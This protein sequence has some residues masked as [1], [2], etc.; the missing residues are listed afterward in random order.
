MS[1]RRHLAHGAA[2]LYKAFLAT[3]PLPLPVFP[4]DAGDLVQSLHGKCLRR[5]VDALG[6]H[7]EGLS[8]VAREMYR[9]KI[10]GAAAKKKLIELDLAYHICRHVT[11]GSIIEFQDKLIGELNGQGGFNSKSSESE[12]SAQDCASADGLQ[13][14]PAPPAVELDHPLPVDPGT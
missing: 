2:A 4:M 12:G 10:I 8:A 11:S 6:V 5:C 7:K 13:T 3:P 1:S 14:P 9:R